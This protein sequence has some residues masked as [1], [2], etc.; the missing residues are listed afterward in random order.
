MEKLRMYKEM[1]VTYGEL[2]LALNF[3]GF[4][5]SLSTEF[6]HYEHKG[7]GARIR[8]SLKMDSNDKVNKGWLVGYTYNMECMGALEHRDDLAKLIE[9]KRL[10]SLSSAN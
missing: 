2:D 3:Y 4:K 10:E 9:Q 1:D 8:V 5:K 7:S 6:V